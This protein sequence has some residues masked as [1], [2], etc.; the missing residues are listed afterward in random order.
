MNTS[1]PS[2]GIF[3][4]ATAKPVLSAI[5]GFF[6]NPVTSSDRPIISQFLLDTETELKECRAEINRLKTSI[7]LLENKKLNLEDCLE[8]CHSLL[9]PIYRLPTE[10]LTDIFVYACEGNKLTSS[11]PPAVILLSTIC[12]RWRNVALTTPRL[13][14]FLAIDLGS[15]KG[16]A[17]HLVSSTMLFMERSKACPLDITI[18]FPADEN[19]TNE[20]IARVFD[21]MSHRCARWRSVSFSLPTHI[22]LPNNLFLEVR[23]Q[24]L[25]LLQSLQI[26]QIPDSKTDG[27]V[28]NPDIFNGVFDVSTSLRTLDVETSFVSDIR[29]P[30]HQITRLTIFRQWSAKCLAF[31]RLFQRLQELHL[32]H[33]VVNAEDSEHLVSNTI[34]TLWLSL[35]SQTDHD[36]LMKHMTLPGL[37]SLTFSS[38][39]AFRKDALQH[40]PVWEATATMDFLARSSCS[41]TSIC[42]ISLPITDRQTIVLLRAMPQLASLQIEELEFPGTATTDPPSNMNRIVTDTL[43]QRLVVKHEGYKLEPPGTVLLPLLANITVKLHAQNLPEQS[44]LAVISSRWIPDI[45]QARDVGVEC[46]RS[47]NIDVMGGEESGSTLDSLR[48]FRD[49]GL[50]LKIDCVKAPT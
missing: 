2:P 8:Q 35:K 12:G 22:T 34:E 42:L 20:W 10:T 9:A 32:H 23:G 39:K 50:R 43:L 38:R 29:L 33:I 21:A 24:A 25:P 47:V 26:R 16:K 3:S 44:L 1:S 28:A 19:G 6:R 30:H 48:C 46:L 40:W 36:T 27:P 11:S 17:D 4:S 37:T 5:R 41:L 49:A 14:S 31:L 7:Y 45:T 15:W 13:W 18:I